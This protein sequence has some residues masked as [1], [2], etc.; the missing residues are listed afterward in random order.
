MI[1]APDCAAVA[2]AIAATELRTE[3]TQCNFQPLLQQ[4]LPP[5]RAARA[6]P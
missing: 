5:C 1:S 3:P 4:G 2:S 6:R